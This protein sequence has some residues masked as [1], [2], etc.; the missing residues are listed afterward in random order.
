MDESGDRCTTSREELDFHLHLE[1]LRATVRHNMTA[2][3]WSYARTAAEI[4]TTAHRVREFLDG[5]AYIVAEDLEPF[6]RCCED[7]ETARVYPEQAALSMLCQEFRPRLRSHISIPGAPGP[8][9]QTCSPVAGAARSS[10]GLRRV[11]GLE[12]DTAAQLPGTEASMTG[13]APGPDRRHVEV[14][15]H[16]EQKR[17]IALLLSGVGPHRARVRSA[18]SLIERLRSEHVAAGVPPPEWIDCL[19]GG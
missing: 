18:R 4:G 16:A 1:E 10:V 14:D 11:E 13:C 3:R 15:R 19:H 8:P 12:A 9:D 17:A 7:L 2:R 6:E 5:R